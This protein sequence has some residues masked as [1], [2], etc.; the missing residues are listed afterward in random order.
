[1]I[2]LPQLVHLSI[3]PSLDHFLLLLL[4]TDYFH[5]FICVAIVVIYGDDVIE[6]Q[7]ATDQMLLHFGNLAMHMNGELILR[8]VNLKI[9]GLKQTDRQTKN[10]LQFCLLQNSIWKAVQCSPFV[11]GVKPPLGFGCEMGNLDELSSFSYLLFVPCAVLWACV[12]TST[13]PSHFQARSLLYQFRLLPRIPC[14]LHD[15]C[16]LCGTGMWD[17]GYIPAVECTGN[18]LDSD[19][20]P[21]G[22]MVDEPSPKPGNESRRGLK[23]REVFAFRK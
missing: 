5:L 3:P 1:M 13:L 22:G 14:G 6:Q 2:L 15:L 16:K 20:C 9:T 18:H 10:P 4:Q 23:T 11:S 17:S 8:K 19:S 7:L 12:F 21:Y